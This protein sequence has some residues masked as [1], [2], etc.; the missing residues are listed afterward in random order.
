MRNLAQRS[1]SAAKEIKDLIN[2]SVQKIE[3][4]TELVNKSGNS[5]SEIVASVDS[6]TEMMKDITGS[7]REQTSGIE[8]INAAIAQ[9]DETTQKN[10]AL[11]EEA[12]AAALSMAD[13][14]SELNG[15]V[16]F[17]SVGAFAT[18]HKKDKPS[19]TASLSASGS[20]PTPK[21]TVNH[22]TAAP[23]KTAPSSKTTLSKTALSKTTPP[24]T[25]LSKTA[26]PK[27]AVK[28]ED[29][30]TYKAYNTQSAHDDDDDWEDF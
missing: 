17:F 12:T 16:S 27:A 13:Q 8:Q 4:G 1:A 7:V 10:A 23:E 21:A 5:L 19:F 20:A 24:K 28:A 2:D 26:S 6:V 22:D 9:M 29:P 14:A 30:I 3:N 18:E 11:V 25:I 15:S